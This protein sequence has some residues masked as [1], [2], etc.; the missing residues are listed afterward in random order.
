MS[1]L[2]RSRR[3]G[4]KSIPEAPTTY[5]PFITRTAPTYDILSEDQAVDIEEAAD[6][7]L[8]NIGVEVRHAPSLELL[9]KAGCRVEG[10]LVKFGRGFCRKLVKD[11]VP[12]EFVQHARNPE[13]S[14]RIG[15][16]SLVMVPIYG[17]P[18]VAATDIERRYGTLEDFNN[19]VRLAHMSPEMHHTGGP[20]CEP[21]D[22]PVSKRHLDMN[23]GHLAY[24]DKCFMGAVTEKERAE[25]T[26][27]MC[28][29]V[30]GKE[31]VAN[32]CVVSALIN[33]NSPLVLD[34]TMLDA[35]HV[36]A[37]AGQACVIAPFVIAG[38]SSP[39][40]IAGAAAQAQ[41]ETLVGMA[42]TQLVRPGA[43][44][45]Y[46]FMMLGMSMRSG[47]PIRY[48]ETWKS[49]LIA[50]Q[51]ARRLGVPFRCGGSSSNSKIPD[52]QSGWEGALYMMYS[53]LS[54]VNFFI[55]ATGTLEAGLVANFDKFLID[56]DMLGAAARMMTGVDTSPEAL[57]LDAIAEVGPAGNFLSC[58]HT[59]KRYRTAFYIPSNADG[60]SF[61][62][63]SASGNLDAAQRAN[64]R[65]HKMLGE[66]EKPALDP[67]IDEALIDFMNRRRAVLPDSFA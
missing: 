52:A 22:I 7:I 40:T 29:I 59:M 1:E 20:I 15:G 16:N 9:K 31:F 67:A 28:E 61:E 65:M 46:G 66:Y 42:I 54:G 5:P 58:A 2:R 3:K 21:T 63:W 34:E 8:Q 44:A 4:R 41:A 62:Q 51:L 60:D 56:C 57:A 11:N 10:N 36:Y 13:K 53:L 50:G 25:N 55:H 12:S 35:A 27:K 33:C 47:S 24:S 64:Q 43:P 38:A 45:I 48:D 32:N 6:D 18:F 17:P 26:I 37:A 14:V 19:F 49:M 39:T 23:Y 30:F